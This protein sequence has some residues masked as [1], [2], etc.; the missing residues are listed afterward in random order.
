MRFVLFFHLT[1][2]AVLRLCALERASGSDVKFSQLDLFRLANVSAK[3]GLTLFNGIRGIRAVHDL[4]P[5]ETL[6]ILPFSSLMAGSPWQWRS[7]SPEIS[8]RYWGPASMS[9]RTIAVAAAELYHG[10]ASRFAAYFEHVPTQFDSLG[11]W[12]EEELWQLH[13][14]ELM[15]Q[16]RQKERMPKQEYH[17]LLASTPSSHISLED[18]ERATELVIS[19]AFAISAHPGPNGPTVIAMVVLGQRGK[20][21][22]CQKPMADALGAWD[23]GESAGAQSWQHLHSC[24]PA[25]KVVTTYGNH[26][27]GF[28]LLNYGFVVP[29]NPFQTYRLG[30]L[31]QQLAATGWRPADTEDP[32]HRSNRAR[33]QQ[34]VILQCRFLQ[35]DLLAL[36]SLMSSSAHPGESDNPDMMT[37]DSELMMALQKALALVRKTW[38]TSL[39]QDVVL[40][41]VGNFTE[42]GYLALQY[43]LHRK[44]ILI[45]CEEGIKKQ[46]KLLSA[47]S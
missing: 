6:V 16:A 34:V 8:Q 17:K 9:A 43:R 46:L 29:D 44:R 14:P 35:P 11:H 10:K 3:L 19:R 24:R 2:L 7:P 5:G 38:V 42:R 27:N 22:H 32:Q 36:K 25:A 4:M 12:T 18:W 37:L 13:D 41:A 26:S 39:E 31:T 45:D 47:P 20:Q 33:L 21:A 40:L 1:L 23:V 30:N 15:S 28:Y